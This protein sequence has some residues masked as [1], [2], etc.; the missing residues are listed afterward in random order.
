MPTTLCET[1]RSLA[2]RTFDQMGRARRVGHQPLEE[3]FT[4]TNILELKDRHPT[5][6]YSR[7]FNKHEEGRNGADWE[8]WLINASITSCLGLRVQA[9]VLDLNSNTFA[10]LHYRSGKSRIYQLTKLK[11]ECANEGLV[12]LY[13]FYLHEQPVPGTDSRRCGSFT[14]SPESYGCALASLPHVEA[15]QA[16]SEL[17]DFG[18]VM[19]QA[20]PWHCLVCCSGYGG[21]DLPQRAW[22]LLQRG[23]GIKPSRSRVTETT[24]APRGKIIGPRSQLPEYV[25]AIVDGRRSDYVP[26]NIRGVLVLRGAEDG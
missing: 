10:H 23:L 20:F 4:D 19:E 15:L 25:R 13:C 22:A 26:P 12:P 6:V 18:S 17:R 8:W 24:Q 2:F 1:F 14:H 7:V 9:K 3:T 5:Q 21:I 16:H 11:R